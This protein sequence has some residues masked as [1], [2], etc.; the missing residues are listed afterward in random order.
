MKIYTVD[1]EGMCPVPHGL[2]ICAKNK[3]EATK[4]AKETITHDQE[5]PLTVMEENIETF[6]K[7]TKCSR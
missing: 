7:E 4:I 5:G 6:S 2:V 1:F 3:R